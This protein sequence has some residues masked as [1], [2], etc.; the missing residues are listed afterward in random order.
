MNKKFPVALAASLI[1]ANGASVALAT[2]VSDSD[3]TT[4]PT[5]VPVTRG[6]SKPTDPQKVAKDARKAAQ[7]DVVA[8]YR[9][10]LAKYLEMKKAII[11]TFQTAMV[12]AK[13]TFNAAIKSAT[14]ADARKAA[15]AAF[16]TAVK[17]ATET[18]NAALKALGAPPKPAKP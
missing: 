8:K 1:L 4:T 9:A 16:K 3:T 7:D 12:D 15:Q 6:K 14:T 2:K 17:T 13:Q 11:T 10:E 18:K 5:T